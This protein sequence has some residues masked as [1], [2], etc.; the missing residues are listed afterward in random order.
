MLCIPVPGDWQFLQKCGSLASGTARPKAYH[1]I[2]TEFP[3]EQFGSGNPFVAF[4]TT[5]RNWF[6]I[7]PSI[8]QRGTPETHYNSSM[9]GMD[10]NWVLESILM[11]EYF[12]ASTLALL[13]DLFPGSSVD[14]R[15]GALS[16]TYLDLFALV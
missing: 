9:Y 16:S 3:F 6:Q 10:S 4:I 2:C 13:S 11:Y 12:V 1:G 15:F 5:L 14:S 8:C 7:N